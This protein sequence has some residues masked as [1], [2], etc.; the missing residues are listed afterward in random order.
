[1]K[2]HL[3]LDL[4]SKIRVANPTAAVH[5]TVKGDVDLKYVLN[6]QAYESKPN[7]AEDGIHACG[8][9]CDGHDHA[10]SSSHLDVT[11]MSVK[12]PVLSEMCAEQLDEWIRT[13][14]WEKQLPNNPEHEIEVLRCKGIYVTD[15]GK[16]HLLQGV[17]ELYE[18][19]DLSVG[20]EEVPSDGK[21]VFIGR[22]LTDRVRHSL[23][24][25]LYA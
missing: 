18:V 21:L 17:R 15:D 20:G 3:L 10:N 19:T 11:S 23:L 9:E 13:V 6:L 5:K 22:G 12:C 25:V 7:F 14:L 2:E 1:M 16:Q 4:E 24:K 8:E